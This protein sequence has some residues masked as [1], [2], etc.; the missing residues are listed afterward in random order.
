[1]TFSVASDG[2]PITVVRMSM[3]PRVQTCRSRTVCRMIET[4]EQLEERRKEVSAAT[5]AQAKAEADLEEAHDEVQ[6][7]RQRLQTLEGDGGSDALREARSIAEALRRELR[8]VA[9][10]RDAAA[11]SA[12]AA[13]DVAAA[14]ADDAAR[15]LRRA[16]EKAGAAQAE[17]EAE[18]AVRQS[19]QRRVE[20]A[21]GAATQAQVHVAEA[22]ASRQSLQR[23]LEAAERVAAEAQDEATRARAAA[24]AAERNA[25]DAGPALHASPPTPPRRRAGAVHAAAMEVR[26]A[27][28]RLSLAFADVE[29]LRETAGADREA[30][31]RDCG[32]GLNDEARDAMARL[33]QRVSALEQERR[34]AAARLEAVCAS[35]QPG[36]E[37]DDR[38]GAIGESGREQD[39]EEAE[40]SDGSEGEVWEG[41]RGV[42][43]LVSAIE[44]EVSSAGGRMPAQGP[45]ARR[46]LRHVAV[47][48]QRRLLAAGGVARDARAAAAA[49]RARADALALRLRAAG[50][51]SDTAEMCLEAE[52]ATAPLVEGGHGSGVVERAEAAAAWAEVA[53]LQ[54]ALRD[55]EQRLKV[56]G[57]E[58]LRLR[59][60]SA[61]RPADVATDS[62]VHGI[63]TLA[64]ASAAA[65][66]EGAGSTTEPTSQ[67]AELPPILAWNPGPGGLA[68]LRS[69]ESV[70]EAAMAT[71][72]TS[73]EL[74]GSSRVATSALFA[75]EL[76]R[77][78]AALQC[79]GGGHGG[80]PSSLPALR[81]GSVTAESGEEVQGMLRSAGAGVAAG[82]SQHAGA[83]QREP[84]GFAQGGGAGDRLVHPGEGG[85]AGDTALPNSAMGRRSSTGSWSGDDGQS[86]A[87]ATGRPTA[88]MHAGPGGHES[89]ASPA[90][91]RGD[92]GDAAHVSARPDSVS[93]NPLLDGDVDSAAQ[94]FLGRL[95][96]SGEAGELREMSSPPVPPR[97]ASVDRYGP[98]I[99]SPL[100]H[101]G[102]QA[103]ADA[104]GRALTPPA[105][106]G[107]LGGSMEGRAGWGAEAA[108]GSAVGFDGVSSN[109]VRPGGG[110]SSEGSGGRSSPEFDASLS[111]LA[112][113]THARLQQIAASGDCAADSGTPRESD[114]G[115]VPAGELQAGEVQSALA[116]VVRGRTDSA[117]SAMPRVAGEDGAGACDTDRDACGGAAT[118]NNPQVRS[119]LSLHMFHRCG[120]LELARVYA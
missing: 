80:V 109:A 45:E 94:Q 16:D 24:A 91:V 115:G 107:G 30:G 73:L 33:E 6:Q 61:A 76:R 29:R 72:G 104:D 7:L 42:D 68:V 55:A 74:D 108:A 87:E 32:S 112:R 17:V 50:F 12:R 26:R 43:K 14:A 20:A 89:P 63:G 92:A 97:G 96:A 66:A 85:V 19:L 62:G 71:P 65:V 5:A 88:R 98:E 60:D 69:P 83:E 56:Q 23:R 13:E 86:A 41:G 35:E 57:E 78:S 93:R 54:A 37:S 58:L 105:V 1:M 3:Q 119:T 106:S 67:K 116:A 31:S 2:R 21:E 53:R 22:A 111:E 77:H 48:V 11:R 113:E 4:D 38:V 102:P 75:E 52:D 101:G 118:G 28:E 117:G 114:G 18:V 8:T 15:A 9:S 59:G 70:A 100:L 51:P 39:P 110:R 95:S 27:D 82:A 84:G 46:W 81:E 34:D 120:V 44:A 64:S 25:L 40:G 36:R 103:Q 99:E 10:E 49:A 47:A 79:G 90:A